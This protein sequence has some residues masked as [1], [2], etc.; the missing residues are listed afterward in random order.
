MRKK[1][2]P[3]Y[4]FSRS[5]FVFAVFVATSAIFI[6][7][8][9]TIQVTRHEVLAAQ[10][11]KQ[12]QNLQQIQAKRGNIY[13]RDM[14]P[15]A[16]TQKAYLMFF[17][18][19][20]VADFE[21]T[22]KAVSK[23]LAGDDIKLYESYKTRFLELL[24]LDLYW[25]AAEHEI[26]PETKNKLS[27]LDIKGVGFEEEPIRFYPEKRLAS[28]VLGYV[29]KNKAGTIQG[30]FGVEGYFNG[31]LRGKPGR[32]IQERDAT[33]S[34]ILVGKYKKD[35]PINGTDIVLTLDRSIQYMVEKKLVEG[36]KKYEADFGSVIV[37][38]ALTGQ[39]L[40]L[41]NYPDYD[42]SNLTFDEE[43]KDMYSDQK[44]NFAVSE[45]YEPGSVIKALTVSSGIDTGVISPNSTFTDA[46]PV[47]YSDYTIDNWDGKHHGVQTITEL[48]QKSNNIGSSWVA[49]QVGGKNL[50]KYFRSFGLGSRSGIEL[51]GEDSG[52]LKAE[53]S[54][55]AIDLATSGF[56]QGM[57]ATPLQVLN[58]FN[59]IAND[60]ILLR[61]RIVM[62]MREDG[63]VITLSTK[64][65][66][67]VMSKESA[68]TVEQMLEE[69]AVGGEAKYFVLKN[70]KI[71]GKTGT[72]QIPKDGKYDPNETNA[73]F[74]GYLS[75]EKKISMLVKLNRPKTS[76]YAA[77]T[78]VPMWMD[79]ATEMIKYYGIA[80]DRL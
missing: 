10:A 44:I 32:V 31:D 34:P 77:E 70:Y 38:D 48:L 73:T 54:L 14:Y 26:L 79:I 33:G 20:L 15:L 61:P 80:P 45:V 57:S 4:T 72:A 60:G 63:R 12:Y 78:A 42:P 76:P 50:Y 1:R 75:G 62:E 7:K 71:A 51:E 18:P 39:I 53:D 8:L 11:S 17:E 40:A 49:H 2:L 28:H 37:M 25:V 69:A 36:V 30:Y 67:R 21:K 66:K 16:A 23:V 13:T 29:A 55:T 35:D 46:G 52:F 6:V 56:G 64:P 22:S 27:E 41:A 68:D 19:K 24:K 3:S 74:V 9:F 59:T 43:K 5:D 65:V 47:N 58:A